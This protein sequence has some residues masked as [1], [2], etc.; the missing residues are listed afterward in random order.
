METVPKS[1]VAGKGSL[2][3]AVPLIGPQYNPISGGSFPTE[4]P[5]TARVIELGG[6]QLPQVN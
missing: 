2:I 6:E 1:T 5:D 3:F 4:V